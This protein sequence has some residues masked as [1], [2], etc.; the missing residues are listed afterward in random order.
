MRQL[1]PRQLMFAYLRDH[2]DHLRLMHAPMEDTDHLPWHLLAAGM[3][4]ILITHLSTS[5]D[6][7]LHA[8]CHKQVLLKDTSD[9]KRKRE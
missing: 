8:E 3:V 6:L 4:M 1:L 9:R 7:L 2:L 5:M